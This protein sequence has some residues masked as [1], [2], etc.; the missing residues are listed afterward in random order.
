M[1]NINNNEQNNQN[2]R[3]P[4]WKIK[5]FCYDSIYQSKCF[6]AQRSVEIDYKVFKDYIDNACNTASKKESIGAKFKKIE[7]KNEYRLENKW[8]SISTPTKLIKG[9]YISDSAKINAAE[10]FGLPIESIEIDDLCINGEKVN[11]KNYEGLIYA[12][13]NQINDAVI[14]ANN[15]PE[16]KLIINQVIPSAILYNDTTINVVNG[17]V[18]IENYSKDFCNDINLPFIQYHLT[19]ADGTKAKDTITLELEDDDNSELSVYDIFFN[20]DVESIYLTEGGYKKNDPI[21][22]KDKIKEYGHLIIKVNNPES[23]PKKGVLY[24]STNKYQLNC[25]K[26]AINILINRPSEYHKSLLLLGDDINKSSLEKIKI[27]YNDVKVDFKVLTK[28]KLHGNKIQQEFIQK[29]L[30][31][32]DFMILEGPPGSGKTTT[33]LEFIYQVLKQGKKILLCASTHVAID[34]VL[35]KIIKHPESEEILKFINPVRIGDENN[36]YVPEVQKYTYERIMDNLAND[37]YRKLTEDSFNLVCGTTIGILR[38]PKFKEALDRDNDSQSIEPLFDYMIIDEASKTT[39]N[40]FLVPAIFAKKWIIVGDVKQLAPYVERNDLTPT[41][42][43]AK[44]LENKEIRKAIHFLTMLET[45]LL[46]MK[47]NVFVMSSSSIEYIN[48]HLK[49]NNDKLIAITNKKLNNIYTITPEDIK[50]KNY[51]LTALC[52]NNQI[53]I[54]EDSLLKKCLDYL[55]TSYSIIGNEQNLTHLNYFNDYAIMHHRKENYSL[56]KE[57]STLFDDYSRR[58]EDEIIWRLIR[59]YE[60]TNNDKSKKEK[61]EKYI[62][63]IK[64][65]L[66]DDMVKDYDDTIAMLEE[67]ALPSIIMLLQNGIKKKSTNTRSTILNSGLS[68]DDK[69]HRFLTLEYQYRMHKDISKI[70][71]NFIYNSKALKDDKRTYDSF[72]YHNDKPRFEIKNITCD[73]VEQNKNENEALAIVEELDTYL[74]TKPK[75]G[76]KIAILTFYNGQVY[77]LRQKLQKYFNVQ[78]KYNFYKDGVEISLNTVDKF[79]G[80]EADVVYLS[81]VQNY[82]VGFLD[83]VNRMNVAITRAKEML[84]IY[85]NV[86]FFKNQKDSELL[87]N[88]FKEAVYG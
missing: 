70:P 55:S 2:T 38:Y 69:Q 58:L 62:N 88:I 42:I 80:Q 79:Q 39:F 82:R 71:R 17:K 84:I 31:T 44:S 29:A 7:K 36:I 57:V 8:I 25:Q 66:D 60:L 40:E 64:E 27:N 65:Y 32:P 34:N 23:F 61:Y 83:S 67:I 16:I 51:R 33:I 20:E 63:S 81:M 87:R 15:N 86:E 9:K 77:L 3:N 43:T 19:K 59:I 6:P 24:L 28:I 5:D 75:T 78:N 47:N 14:L 35:E 1:D 46:K 73:L 53:I 22:V 74:Q 21:S 49:E 56:Q 76:L 45:N 11:Y 68:E 12:P 30:V 85:G 10:E 13:C 50:Q 72:S 54:S 48:F 26:N 52:A 18:W 4:K 37:E 41:L